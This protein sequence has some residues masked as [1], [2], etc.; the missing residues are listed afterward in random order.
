MSHKLCQ[1]LEKV[2]CSMVHPTTLMV[3]IPGH[4]KSIDT[5]PQKKFPKFLI[6]HTYL[7]LQPKECQRSRGSHYVPAI[8]LLQNSDQMFPIRKTNLKI[9]RMDKNSGQTF[10][11]YLAL[12][13]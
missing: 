5:T 8:Y 4:H 10:Y 11:V 2:H 3:T 1:N 12:I 6:Y 7:K 9:Y 13:A